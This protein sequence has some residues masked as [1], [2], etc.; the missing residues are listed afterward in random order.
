MGSPFQVAGPFENGLRPFC[1]A[2]EGCA[3][4]HF[5]QSGNGSFRVATIFCSDPASTRA[6]T[7]LLLLSFAKSRAIRE[8][9]DATA[10]IAP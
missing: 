3:T 4:N 1:D 6:A 2:L 9:W 10:P 5:L 8:Y 7:G